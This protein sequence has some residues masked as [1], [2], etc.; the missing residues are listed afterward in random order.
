METKIIKMDT[1]VLGTKTLIKGK[2]KKIVVK[3]YYDLDGQIINEGTTTENYEN[4]VDFEII[5]KQV[6]YNWKFMKPT[7]TEQW[8]IKVNGTKVNYGELTSYRHSSRQLTLH[9]CVGAG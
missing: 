2:T 1:E 7:I 9:A 3:N 8:E 4:E 6:K 5:E